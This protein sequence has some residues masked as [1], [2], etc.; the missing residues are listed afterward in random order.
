MLRLEVG[1]QR[2]QC[3]DLRIRHLPQ[4]EI[5][6]SVQ[7]AAANEQ[8]GKRQVPAIEILRKERFVEIGSTDFSLLERPNHPANCLQDFQPTGITH[9]NI[10]HQFCVRSSESLDFI[11]CLLRSPRQKLLLAK[12]LKTNAKP[13]EFLTIGGQSQRQKIVEYGRNFVLFAPPVLH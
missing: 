2:V 1:P 10:Y 9:R 12:E 6:D 13:V 3:Y 5:T 4:H 8:I 7:A 11:D